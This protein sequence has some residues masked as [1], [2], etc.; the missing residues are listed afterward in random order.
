MQSILKRACLAFI[1][2]L[3][4]GSAYAGDGRSGGR[5]VPADTGTVI[6]SAQR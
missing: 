5:E 4:A 3:F 1:G 2:V 6:P